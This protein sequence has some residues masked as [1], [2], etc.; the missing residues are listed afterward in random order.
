MVDPDIAGRKDG[1]GIPIAPAHTLHQR[2]V[3]IHITKLTGFA[4]VN[5]ESMDYNVAHVI[6][7]YAG[8]VGDVAPLS[9]IVL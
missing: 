9:S 2:P 7:K 3:P 5:A 6:K 4:M 8:V 1:Y